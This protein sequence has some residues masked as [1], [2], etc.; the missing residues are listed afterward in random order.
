MAWSV[1][2]AL[3]LDVLAAVG[4]HLYC[5]KH[6]PED[7]WK[8]FAVL[9]SLPLVPASLFLTHTSFLTSLAIAFSVF[10]SAL[11]CS[12]TLYRISPLHPLA[13]YP[14]PLLWRITKF[15]AA[16]YGGHGTY[17]IKLKQLHDYY[18]PI[19]RIGPNELSI[20]QADLIPYILGAQGMPKGPRT[21]S[22]CSGLGATD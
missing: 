22:V 14:G 15:S 20:I 17:H 2:Q 3:L 10:F 1:Q 11:L 19:V 6:E 5:R 7:Y 21:H 16:W 8:L 9:V 4:V 12:I 18:G 13:R